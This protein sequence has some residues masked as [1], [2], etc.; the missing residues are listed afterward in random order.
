MNVFSVLNNSHCLKGVS[1]E[2]ARSKSIVEAEK[3]ALEEQVRELTD[4]LKVGA[5]DL[6]KKEVGRQN[7]PH[8]HALSDKLPW[9]LQDLKSIL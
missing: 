2:L 6:S 1:E 4:E 7:I 8:L 3:A 9:R 5:E